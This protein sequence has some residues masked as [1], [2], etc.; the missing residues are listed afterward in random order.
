MT[1]PTGPSELVTLDDVLAHLNIDNPTANQT[2]EL[3][4]F[5]DAATIYIQAQTGPIIPKQFTETHNGGGTTIVLRNPPVMQVDSVVEYVGP[6]GYTL[7]RADLGTDSGAYSYSLDDPRGGII[8]RRWNGGLVGAFIGG[9]RNVLVTYW[10]GQ[11]ADQRTSAWRCCRTSPACTSRRSWARTL[12]ATT[13][14]WV[15]PR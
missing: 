9:E 7:T 5:I 11:G 13:P 6:T 4:G 8:R 3:Q 10:G 1:Q 12:T 15:T 14:R 2:T